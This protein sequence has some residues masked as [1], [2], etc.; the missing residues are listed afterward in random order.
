MTF[1]FMDESWKDD[2]FNDHPNI[3]MAKDLT[4]W[5]AAWLPGCLAYWLIDSQ[6]DLLT[7][8]LTNW[9]ATKLYDWS[10]DCLYLM[11]HYYED[12]YPFTLTKPFS[13]RCNSCNFSWQSW[14]LERSWFYYFSLFISNNK[15]L[16]QSEEW[17][18]LHENKQI[19]RTRLVWTF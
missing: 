4:D 18:Q 6:T 1:I 10:I 5:V 3:F 16:N 8:C 2:H 9:L 14:I 15:Q 12:L 17:L 11:W 19:W 13:V 7:D